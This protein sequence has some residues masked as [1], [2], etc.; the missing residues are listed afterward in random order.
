[1]DFGQAGIAETQQRKQN[2]QQTANPSWQMI[3]PHNNDSTTT[4]DAT[5]INGNGTDTTTTT[6]ATAMNDNDN[7]VPNSNVTG[8]QINAKFHEYDLI[9]N[10]LEKLQVQGIKAQKAIDNDEKQLKR[11]IKQSVKN[12]N[13]ED[14]DTDDY[15]DLSSTTNSDPTSRNMTNDIGVMYQ[16]KNSWY[17]NAN[18]LAGMVGIG[19]VSFVI[20]K[21][22]LSKYKSNEFKWL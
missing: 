4:E 11:Q 3:S 14:T 5:N 9:E 7:N 1:M 13:E 12:R 18:I 19:V 15:K 20:Y 6:T 2:E 17:K 10:Q 22:Y 8:H 21:V 16:N